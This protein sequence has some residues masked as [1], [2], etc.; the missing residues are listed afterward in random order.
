MEE[1]WTPMSLN[2]YM[3]DETES[4]GPRLIA[5]G[6]GADKLRKELGPAFSLFYKVSR[7]EAGRL[8][9]SHTIRDSSFGSWVDQ[10][11]ALVDSIGMTTE[12]VASLRQAVAQPYEVSPGV[13]AHP[14]TYLHGRSDP[15][16][17][18]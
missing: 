16:H 7:F 14:G 6:P 10:M 8:G 2:Y 18:G 4:D 17:V 12:A 13:T 9:L 11:T 5:E 3:Y 15:W 1:S